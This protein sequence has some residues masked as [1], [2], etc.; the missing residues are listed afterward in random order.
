MAWLAQLGH[1]AGRLVGQGLDLLYPPRCVFCKA[2]ESE[3]EAALA[4]VCQTC[5]RILSTDGPRCSRCGEPISHCEHPSASVCRRCNRRPRFDGIV[6]LAGYDDEIRSAV[7]T[8]KRPGGELHAAGLAT[9]LLNRHRETMCSWRL[10]LVVPVPMHWLRRA[11][12]GASS[13]DVL[14]RHVAKGLGLPARDIMWRTRATT[15]QNELPPEERAANVRDAFR[16]T[17]AASGK[18]IMLV[19][20][21]STTGST[22]DVC[23]DALLAAGAASVFAAVMARADRGSDGIERGT[24]P[25]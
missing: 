15:M 4:V 23:R 1:V 7:L 22:L 14:A 16:A 18:R 8:A 10:D 24:R 20:D 2:E 6:V 19:D 9:L 5:R 11:T 12:R 21:V 17:P 25:R 3:G 13:A